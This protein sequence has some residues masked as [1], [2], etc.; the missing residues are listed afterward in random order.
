MGSSTCRGQPGGCRKGGQGAMKG[1]EWQAAC[2]RTRARQSPR[3]ARRADGG[4]SGSRRRKHGDGTLGRASRAGGAGRWEVWAG[5]AP[6]HAGFCLGV[7]PPISP[8]G[9]LLLHQLELLGVRA[10]LMVVVGHDV[11]RSQAADPAAGSRWHAAALAASAA[12]LLGAQLKCAPPRADT[13][14]PAST[15]YCGLGEPMLK[16][17]TA[18]RRGRYQSTQA[19]DSDLAL[20]FVQFQ[21]THLHCTFHQRPHSDGPIYLAARHFCSASTRGRTCQ[22]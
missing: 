2:A 9:A 21:Y 16:S 22:Q 13:C 8:L 20:R 11:V 10:S 17:L 14:R 15:R 12:A 7:Q 5:V 4:G 19:N 3:A 18:G 6:H 1:R